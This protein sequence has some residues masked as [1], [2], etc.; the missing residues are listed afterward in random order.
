MPTC[1]LIIL[2]ANFILAQSVSILSPYSSATDESY[3]INAPLVAC[4]TSTCIINCI[5]TSVCYR[6]HYSIIKAKPCR[7]ESTGEPYLANH[8]L[9]LEKLDEYKMVIGA[10]KFGFFIGH[11]VK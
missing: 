1:Y 8:S 3:T 6:G 11:K 10:Q 7:V 2:A 4:G 9:S 5:G